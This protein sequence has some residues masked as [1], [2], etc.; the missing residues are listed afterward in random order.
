MTFLRKTCI[1]FGAEA[2]LETELKEDN[3]LSEIGEMPVNH[4]LP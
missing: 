3:L 1:D 4:S 2:K